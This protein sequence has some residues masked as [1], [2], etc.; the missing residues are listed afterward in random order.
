MESAV[1]IAMYW[2]SWAMASFL[3]GLAKPRERIAPQRIAA[4]LGEVAEM[5]DAPGADFRRRNV[6]ARDGGRRIVPHQCVHRRAREHLVV[7]EGI[8]EHRRGKPPVRRARLV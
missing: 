3:H 4:R 2:T 6:T 8:A 7:L 1:S 5:A